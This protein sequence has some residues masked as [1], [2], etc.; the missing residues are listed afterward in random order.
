MN[1]T[2]KPN[3]DSLNFALLDIA[4]SLDPNPSRDRDFAPE[5]DRQDELKNPTHDFRIQFEGSIVILWPDS[6]RALQ[7][8]YD[9]LPET[10]D[11]WGKNGYVIETRFIADVAAG[12]VRDGLEEKS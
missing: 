1:D 8:C 5:R 9:H 11:R 7:W 4:E 2:Y 3:L 6:K 10:C 12:M